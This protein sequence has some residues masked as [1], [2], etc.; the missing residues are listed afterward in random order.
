VKIDRLD[1]SALHYPFRGFFKFIGPAA[2][3]TVALVKLTADDGTVGWGQSLPNPRW[4]YETLETALIVLREYLGPA[5]LGRDPLDIPA[6][7]EALDRALAPSFSTAMPITRA[8]LDL[9]LHDL[10]GKLSGRSVAEMWGRPCGGH[11]RLSWTVNVQSLDEVDAQVEAGH[12][13]GYRN[14]NLKIA[15]NPQLDVALARRVRALAP[16]GF[17]WADANGGYDLATALEVAPGLADA[18]VDVLEAPL[19]PNRISGYQALKRQGA[20]PITMDEGVVSPVDLEEFIRLGM[21]DGITLKVSRCGGLFAA[22]RQIEIALDAG[23]FWLGSG[24]TDPD[25]SLAGSLI[26]FGAYGL[27]RPAALNAPQYLGQSVLARPLVVCGDRAEVPAGPGL[28]VEV[29]E[30]KVALLTGG[31]APLP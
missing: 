28:G 17:L 24:L 29:D 20:V 9:A 10:A 14:F 22:R 12:Q 18:G 8:G 27:A 25:V 19:R 21:I 7:Q 11:V 15:P 2:V 4:S 6:A 30:A 3:H 13:R 31:A 1:V 16:D 23:L 5:L 26:L